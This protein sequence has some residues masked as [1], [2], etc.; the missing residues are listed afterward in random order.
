MRAGDILG[1]YG[2]D[3]FLLI[4]PDTTHDQAA[5]L[6]DRFAARLAAVSWP[7]AS[8]VG[9]PLTAGSGIATYPDDARA[10]SEL[11]ALA[12]AALY[13]QK[14]ACRPVVCS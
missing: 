4:L 3:E 7:V 2:G 6:L 1:R 5:A 14:K 12:D 8:P 9:A 10:A 11:I 13:A